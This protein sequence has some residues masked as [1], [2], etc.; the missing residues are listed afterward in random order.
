MKFPTIVVDDGSK[1]DTAKLA[2]SNGAKVLRHKINRGKGASLKTGFEY[3]L[4]K[5]K[6]CDAILIMDG[7]GQH[8][9]KDI[10]KFT[11][12]AGY[13]KD[14]FII[15]NRMDNPINMPLERKL[16][17][18]FMSKIVSNMCRQNIPDSQCGF[19]L[20]KKDF[21]QKLDIEF[22]RFEVESE[23]LMKASQAGFKIVSVP[24][25]TLYGEESSRI[26]PLQDT[27][28]FIVFLF[29]HFF[30]KIRS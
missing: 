24:I 15:G 16:T 2:E 17:N 18:R 28:R 1:D 9:P 6:L 27:L 14:I 10:K 22:L 4:R 20:L 8:S 3:I 7:D 12:L 29:K 11:D 30:K 5:D 23:L 19:R 21:V 13:E 26:N 25:Q